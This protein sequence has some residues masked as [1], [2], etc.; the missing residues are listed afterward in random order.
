MSN[1]PLLN[2]AGEPINPNIRYV[3]VARRG[4]LGGLSAGT[5]TVSLVLWAVRTILLGAPASDRPVTTGIAPDLL[6]FGVLGAAVLAGGLAWWRLGAI[7]STFRRGGLSLV[8]AVATVVVAIAATPI[9]HALGRNGLLALAALGA[10]GTIAFLR[11][12]TDEIAA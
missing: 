4:V 6:L 10:A 12:R 5:L 7:E 9:Y 2:V 8:A 11:P 3:R 1:P